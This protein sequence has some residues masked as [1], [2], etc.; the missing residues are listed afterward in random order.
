ALPIWRRDLFERHREAGLTRF[1]R[2]ARPVRLA[3]GAVDFYFEIATAFVFDLDSGKAERGR[4]FLQ[5][6]RGGECGEMS[7]DSLVVHA[8]LRSHARRRR[9]R[10]SRSANSGERRNQYEQGHAM[11]RA[12]VAGKRENP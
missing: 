5:F 11:H 7:E 8:N 12:T 1:L 6:L 2:K 4:V 9:S 10:R 3:I